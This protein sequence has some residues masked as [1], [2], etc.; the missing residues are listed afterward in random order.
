M[1]RRES[2]YPVELRVGRYFLIVCGK[3]KCKSTVTFHNVN[4]SKYNL[5]LNCSTFY[6]ATHARYV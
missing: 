2:F 6:L 5:D 3:T 1:L 4:K